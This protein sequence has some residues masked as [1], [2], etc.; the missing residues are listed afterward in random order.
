MGRVDW[1]AIEFADVES[2]VINPRAAVGR[3]QEVGDVVFAF[4]EHEVSAVLAHDAHILH[5]GSGE[6]GVLWVTRP[7]DAVA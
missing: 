7:V 3:F 2:P 6:Y 5:P 1:L 4:G